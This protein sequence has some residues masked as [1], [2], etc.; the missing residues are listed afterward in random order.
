MA[1]CLFKCTFPISLLFGKYIK[2]C[3]ITEVNSSDDS[4]HFYLKGAKVILGGKRHS[5][6]STFYEPTIVSDVNNEMR[7]S[8]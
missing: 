6:G 4:I 2:V 5:L 1:F 3:Q 8:R 7:I